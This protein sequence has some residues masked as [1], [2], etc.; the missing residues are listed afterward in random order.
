MYINFTITP[1]DIIIII[2]VLLVLAFLRRLAQ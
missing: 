1:R 2:T